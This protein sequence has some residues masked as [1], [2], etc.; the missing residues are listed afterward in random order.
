MTIMFPPAGEIAKTRLLDVATPTPLQFRISG[1]CSF[2]N[3]T[4]VQIDFGCLLNVQSRKL[5]LSQ[6]LS[7]QKYCPSLIQWFARPAKFF[8]FNCKQLKGLLVNYILLIIRLTALY[9][10]WQKGCF[11]PD[12]PPSH[13]TLWPMSSYLW[14][15]LD[16]RIEAQ[17]S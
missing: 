2:F 5:M 4:C 17:R 15:P 13:S 11:L 1:A 8:S 12:A 9:T 14:L 7:F 3:P 6:R 10:L 16:K